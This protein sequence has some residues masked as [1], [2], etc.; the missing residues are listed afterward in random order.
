MAEVEIKWVP[1]SVRYLT[2]PQADGF[3]FKTSWSNPPEN[4][5]QSSWRQADAIT[6]QWTV[7]YI[8]DGKKSTDRRDIF[9]YDN[10]SA[11]SS[12][13]DLL[14]H[15]GYTFFYPRGKNRLLKVSVGVR[16]TNA[17]GEPVG[18]N[19]GSVIANRLLYAPVEPTIEDAEF[20]EDAGKVI[21]HVECEEATPRQMLYDVEWESVRYDSRDNSKV[22]IKGTEGDGSG[23]VE[24]DVERDIAGYQVLQED[25]NRFFK[26]TTRARA[27]GSYGNSSWVE[28]STFL[29]LPRRPVIQGVNV[30][31]LSNTDRVTV[32]FAADTTGA[33]KQSDREAMLRQHPFT[34]CRL[35]YLKDVTETNA[36]TAYSMDG[37]E[38]YDVE[39]NGLCT[40]LYVPASEVRPDPDKITWVRVKCW[41][42]SEDV[43]WRASVPYRLTALET[44]SPTAEDDVVVLGDLRPGKDG[45]SI[46]AD[47]YWDKDRRTD[48]STGTQVD[49]SQ[50]GYAWASTVEPSTYMTTRNDATSKDPRKTYEGNDYYGFTTLYIRDLEIAKRYYVK[51]RR[52]MEG[53]NGTTYGPW[54]QKKS[55]VVGNP[56]DAVTLSAPSRIPIGDPLP[57]TWE[58]AIDD[59]LKQQAQWQVVCGKSAGTSG[60]SSEIGHLLLASGTGGTRAS[61]P[62]DTVSETI[63]S[64]YRLQ[65]DLLPKIPGGEWSIDLTVIVGVNGGATTASNTVRVT[66]KSLPQ[67]TLLRAG[68]PDN[69]R[70]LFT[71]TGQPIGFDV[72]ASER[73]SAL[74]VVV[75]S[76]GATGDLPDGRLLQEDGDCLW[77][78]RVTDATVSTTSDAR[79]PYAYHVTIPTVMEFVDNSYCTLYVRGMA[80]DGTRGNTAQGVFYIDW[81]HKASI[82]AVLTLAP[83]DYVDE[84]GNRHR[85]VEIGPLWTTPRNLCPFFSHSLQDDDFWT[86]AAWDDLRHKGESQDDGWYRTNYL[87]DDPV[88]DCSP[89]IMACPWIEGGKTYTL[90]FETVVRY[91]T[92]ITLEVRSD[93]DTPWIQGRQVTVSNADYVDRRESHHITITTKPDISG[94]ESLGVSITTEFSYEFVRLSIYEGVYDDAYAPVSDYAKASND[95]FSLYRVTT[96]GAYRI[97][98]G[99]VAGDSVTDPYAPFG[100]LGGAYRLCT[101]TED[102]DMCWRDDEYELPGS[103]MRIDFG[104]SYVELPYDVS[105][106]D[107]FL[108]DFEARHHY[109]EARPEGYWNESVTRTSSLSA[110]LIRVKD[111]DTVRRVRQLAQHAGPCFVRL[112]NGCAFEADVQVDDVSENRMGQIGIDI[113]LKATEIAPTGA[114]EIGRS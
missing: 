113:S 18:P 112:P 46:I 50:D 28:K 78:G 58:V 111:A 87:N 61:V 72:R 92:S 73:L 27:R 94:A 36:Q 79:W 83:H 65:K 86:H 34:G 21:H 67:V 29:S 107:S 5:R 69:Q 114:Y 45:T 62:G 53:E 110:D 40:A 57:L 106:S 19:H 6:I 70:L 54:S 55:A 33:A 60:S 13:I 44:E 75:R 1:L 99:L 74:D 105:M 93:D 16:P 9:M 14:A 90:L 64:L 30:S 104:G 10:G 7:W 25:P 103:D 37:W 56:P 52:Y 97:A 81:E 48:D 3:E 12:T 39:D 89:F 22:T 49:W 76:N 96:D 20:D 84:N 2:A 51:A 77:S 63:A 11:T 91:N 24:L 88:V 42:L 17:I 4:T 100:E 68:Q 102:G 95:T 41:N 71:A 109:G 59:E 31:Q 8:E 32:R 35:Q 23:D 80:E 43:L 98:S 85:E 47:L 66:I 38:D 26:L 82:P 15:F 101:V 108:K